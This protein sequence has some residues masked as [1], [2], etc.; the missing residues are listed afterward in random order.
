MPKGDSAGELRTLSPP[1][2]KHRIKGFGVFFRSAL[3]IKEHQ[4]AVRCTGG[5]K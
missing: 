5:E 3:I 1:S 4:L 2:S